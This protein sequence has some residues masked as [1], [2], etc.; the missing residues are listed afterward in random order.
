MYDETCSK[1]LKVVYPFIRKMEGSKVA[2]C[3][4]YFIIYIFNFPYPSL[5]M[6]CICYL[7][8]LNGGNYSSMMYSS[9]MWMSLK[10][11]NIF[12]GNDRGWLGV[13][14]GKMHHKAYYKFQ[15]KQD[16]L[17]TRRILDIPWR[18][19]HGN[20]NQ[21]QIIMIISTDI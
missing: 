1:V 13:F 19:F 7:I 14:F 10:A 11:S 16:T 18:N 20:I 3:F 4:D 2:L 9:I 5:Q 17:L 15:E 6:I 12:R 21:C 8:Y